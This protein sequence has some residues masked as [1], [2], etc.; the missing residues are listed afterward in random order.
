LISSANTKFANDHPETVKKFLAAFRKAEATWD[1]GFVDKDGKRADEPMGKKM[2]EIASKNLGSPPE[3]LAKGIPYYDPQ[4]RVA[5]A[6]VQRAIDWYYSQGM[7]K[8]KLDAASL[9][10][11]RFALLA[12]PEATQ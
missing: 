10:D 11:K 8:E 9:V 3:V 1:S 7:I 2:M 4:S 6:D 12:Q 5:L